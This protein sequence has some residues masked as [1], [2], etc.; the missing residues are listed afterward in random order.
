MCCVCVDLFRLRNNRPDPFF[1][2]SAPIPSCTSPYFQQGT[3]ACPSSDTLLMAW[4]LMESKLHNARSR[5]VARALL[6]R[7][8]ALNP[9]RHAGVLKWRVFLDWKEASE[10]AV[11]AVRSALSNGQTVITVSSEQSA[12]VT[13]A[14]PASKVTEGRGGNAPS[15]AAAVSTTTAGEH[16]TEE[17]SHGRGGASTSSGNAAVA[18]SSPRSQAGGVRELPSARQASPPHQVVNFVTGWGRKWAEEKEHGLSTDLLQLC[19]ALAEDAASGSAGAGGKSVH[20]PM[21]V[22][23]MKELAAELERTGRGLVGGFDGGGRE[24]SGT[25]RLV[26]T[27]CTTCNRIL[28]RAGTTMRAPS[29]FVSIVSRTS[30][31]A[32]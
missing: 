21:R 11:E 25:W 27:T 19:E 2:P 16:R 12:T 8:V 24:L 23:R 7:A 29:T 6:R 4:A 17:R 32:G 9:S 10:A 13:P 1:P 31:L 22:V 3:A 5:K 20:D 30:R 28:T 14:A 15:A 18:P 26:F